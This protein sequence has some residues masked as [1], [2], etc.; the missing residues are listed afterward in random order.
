MTIF[1]Y[2][3]Q[4]PGKTS[5]EIAWVICTAEEILIV[6]RAIALAG[7]IFDAGHRKEIS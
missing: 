4:N 2:V 7:A 1:E 6:E 5:S 3:S